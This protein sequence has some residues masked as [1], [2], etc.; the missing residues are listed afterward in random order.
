MFTQLIDNKG[1][2]KIVGKSSANPFFP[3]DFHYRSSLVKEPACLK[4]PILLCYLDG[5]LAGE[6]A[7]LQSWIKKQTD[8]KRSHIA[9]FHKMSLLPYT[10]QHDV[11]HMKGGEGGRG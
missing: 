3:Q 10:I 9:H 1:L 7:T 2:T 6:V 11:L 8:N 5:Q 4:M